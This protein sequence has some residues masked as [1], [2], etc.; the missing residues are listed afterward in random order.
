MVINSDWFLGYFVGNTLWL[1]SIGYYLYITFLGYNGESF[2]HSF[3]PINVVIFVFFHLISQILENMRSIAVMF[4]ALGKC[5][6]ETITED[7]LVLAAFLNAVYRPLRLKLFESYR[8]CVYRSGTK[9]F[10]FH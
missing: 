1:I 3:I 10:F 9:R 7:T 6:R 4:V 5:Y 2:T 8:N